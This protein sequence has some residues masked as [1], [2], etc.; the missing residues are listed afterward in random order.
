MKKLRDIPKE[1]DRIM[2]GPLRIV[3]ERVLGNKPEKIRIEKVT[4]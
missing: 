4:I 2:I 1:G 3:V